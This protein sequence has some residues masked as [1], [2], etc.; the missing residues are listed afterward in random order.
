M[1]YDQRQELL[2]EL[3]RI[4]ATGTAPIKLGIGCVSYHGTVQDEVVIYDCPPAFIN[5]L[6]KKGYSLY[7]ENGAIH[8]MPKPM[9]PEAS[10]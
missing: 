3:C 10:Q 5:E 1:N 6:T 4:Q 8:I 9:S 7:A 2:K